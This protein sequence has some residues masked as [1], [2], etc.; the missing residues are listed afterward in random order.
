MPH[1]RFAFVIR[2]LAAAFL[3]ATAAFPSTLR[4]DVSLTAD[5][6]PLLLDSL[7]YANTAEETFS[8]TR[9]SFLLSGFALQQD[10]GNWLELPG[11][12]AWMDAERRRLETVL[13]NIPAGKYQALRFHLGLDSATNAAA[14][15][16]YA[17]DHPLNPNLN[18]LHWSWQG[19]YIFLALE[20]SFRVAGQTP[21]GFSYHLARDPNRTA[22]T[23]TG[24]FDLIPWWPRSKPICLRLSHCSRFP[25]AF[26]RSHGPRPSNRSTFRPSTRRIDSR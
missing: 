5:N 19:G 4:L 8:I 25:A 3:L 15:A 2:Q 20:G 24:G 26:L 23:F 10:D 7:R 13:P 21:G 16:Q 6:A 17:P 9:C 14:P 1:S 18:G 22:L 11:H 12:T